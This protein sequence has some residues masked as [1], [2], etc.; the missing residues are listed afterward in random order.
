MAIPDISSATIGTT[1]LHTEHAKRPNNKGTHDLGAS[2]FIKILTTQL[3]HQNPLEPMKDTEFIHQM[4]QFNELEQAREMSQTLK[5]N[6]YLGK[7]V[8]IDSNESGKTTEVRGEVTAYI[9]GKDGDKVQ[10]KGVE[11]PVSSIRRV[12][13]SE[14]FKAAVTQKSPEAAPAV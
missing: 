14:Q 12:E 4:S 2:D 10:V 13:I 8:T 11:Y 1:P 6:T 9:K 3:T 7:T 5:A